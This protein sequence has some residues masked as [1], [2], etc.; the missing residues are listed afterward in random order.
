MAASLGYD[1]KLL[2]IAERVGGTFDVRVHP[3]FIPN[4]HKYFGTH[5]LA[6]IKGMDNGALIYGKLS[7][8]QFFKGAGAGREPTALAVLYDLGLILNN[9]AQQKVDAVNYWSQPD[10]ELIDQGTRDTPGFIR[11]VS[12]DLP[13][14][15]HV[16]TGVLAK[17]GLGIKG[18]YQPDRI[19][20]REGDMVPDLVQVY[21]R[22][23]ASIQEALRELAT[24]A[25][26]SDKPLF[27]R[28][29]K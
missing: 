4:G 3:C 12:K 6:Q 13:G 14:T 7:G 24:S 26:C 25:V 20:D 16:I 9:M 15:L 21:P 29:E 11:T 22:P 5:T 19:S 27:Y 23:Y 10:A 28:V 1:V 2:A 18:I 8:P 17:H